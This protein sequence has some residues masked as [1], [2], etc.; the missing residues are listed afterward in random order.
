MFQDANATEISC[1]GSTVEED[2][3]PAAPLLE[4]V[5]YASFE[6]V[7]NDLANMVLLSCLC[8]GYLRLSLVGR[9]FTALAETHVCTIHSAKTLEEGKGW[10]DSTVLVVTK[11]VK[12]FNS[13]TA[14]CTLI[15]VHMPKSGSQAP[16]RL[17]GNVDGCTIE[18]RLFDQTKFR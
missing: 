8:D 10:H 13:T 7:A 9:T 16:L 2:C 18:L 12:V 5:P 15:T 4:D 1:T 3:T 6:M 11:M 17:V 14:A